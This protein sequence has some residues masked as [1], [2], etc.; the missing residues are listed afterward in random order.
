MSKA[1]T[2]WLLAIRPKTL[3][4]SVV[5]VGLG[6]ALA[7]SE[8]GKIDVLLMLV[9]LAAAMCIQIGTNLHNDVADFERGTDDAAT[10]LGP[11]RVTAEGWLSAAWVRIGAYL[12]FAAALLLGV[13]LIWQGGWPILLAG[14]ASVVAAV[15][16]TGG[17]RPLAYIG[18]GEL[19]VWFFFGVVAVGGSY[20]LQAGGVGPGALLA[21][22]IIGMPAAA[23]LVVNNY[24]DLDN[25]RSAG[26]NTLAVRYGRG[27]SRVEYAALML[28]PFLLLAGWQMTM[29]PH[30]GLLLPWLTLPWA[31]WLVQR[32]RSLPAGPAFNG[33][34]AVTAMF[35][36]T[37]GLLLAL[38]LVLSA[39]MVEA[40]A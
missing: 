29:Q 32:F 22:T 13:Y 15:A 40:C 30:G 14:L 38:A 4:I 21:G 28:V 10:R 8:T 5:P 11:S 34:L 35:Q 36:F 6:C 7:W 12:S 24:R 27:F 16:Y 33:L 39:R 23:V 9:T 26:K 17:P 2:Y 3:T 18:L 31:L 1:F 19:F 37:L 20:F 25:D